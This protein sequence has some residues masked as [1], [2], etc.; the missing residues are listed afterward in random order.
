MDER[1]DA[2]FIALD[3]TYELRFSNK[4]LKELCAQTGIKMGN[5]DDAINDIVT[6]QLA[7]YILI[8]HDCIRQGLPVPTQAAVEDMLDEY[9]SPA[10]LY[11]LL[12]DALTAAYGGDADVNAALEARGQTPTAAAGTG[13]RA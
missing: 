8:K 1:N 3:R 11:M 6:Q 13:G 10:K 2:V 12:A 9:V 4:A 5:M 7:A